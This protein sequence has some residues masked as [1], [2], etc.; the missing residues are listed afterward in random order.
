MS[1]DVR[2]TD[3][4]TRRVLQAPREHGIRGGTYRAGGDRELSLSITYNYGS[5]FCREDVL[6]ESGIRS[7]RGM[8]GAESIPLLQRAI[9]ALGDEEDPDYWEPAEGNGKRALCGLLAFAQLRPD[10]VW[11]VD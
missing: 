11:E 5:I 2:L 8:T 1:W 7:L 4:V 10:G 3:P 9:G 6:G